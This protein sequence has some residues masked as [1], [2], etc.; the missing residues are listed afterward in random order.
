MQKFRNIL[1]LIFIFLTIKEN[2][3]FAAITDLPKPI[4]GTFIMVDF[5]YNTSLEWQ[6]YFDDLKSV[7]IDTIIFSSG[8]I[9]CK[10]DGT[11]TIHTMFDMPP[12][13]PNWESSPLLMVLKAAHLNNFH[14]FLAYPAVDRSQNNCLQIDS[15]VSW[16]ILEGY[17]KSIFDGIAQ[18]YQ[19]YGWTDWDTQVIGYYIGDELEVY[20]FAPGPNQW[21]GMAGWYSEFSRWSKQN[22]PD[23]KVLLSPYMHETDTYQAIY[24]NTYYAAANWNIDIYAPQDSV[25]SAKTRT[26]STDV[27]HFQALHDAIAKANIDKGKQVEAWA[28]VESFKCPPTDCVGQAIWPATDFKTLRWQLRATD[29]F[30]TNVITWT[31]QWSLTTIPMLNNYGYYTPALA[32]TRKALK[33]EYINKPIILAGFLWDTSFVLKGYNFGPANAPVKVYLHTNSGSF[34]TTAI[35]RNTT[36]PGKTYSEVWIPMTTFPNFNVNLS[37]DVALENQENFVSYFRSQ[38]PDS[39]ND[40]SFPEVVPFPTPTINPNPGDANG[41]FKVNLFDF[42]ILINHF[43]QMVTGGPSLADFNDD[44]KVDWTDF[45]TLITNFGH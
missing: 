1:I 7:G 31:H 39:Q 20:K 42:S 30:V 38:N 24:D 8:S 40:P 17:F 15:A 28:N 3:V 33:N 29:F 5:T 14:V 35:S 9:T 16:P 10:A 32:E 12:D 18:Q 36:D 21:P 37:F 27:S 26:Y 2:T 34:N 22:Y 13:Y 41:D 43:G 44:G 6:A 19:A 4:K 11:R 25:G 23:K 45:S